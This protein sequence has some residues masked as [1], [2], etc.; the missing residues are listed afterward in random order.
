LLN[1]KKLY[2][3]QASEQFKAE[4]KIHHPSV[5]I[6]WKSSDRDAIIGPKIDQ[7]GPKWDKS[8]TFSDES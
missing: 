6:S 8:A 4:G 7:I 3:I 2:A 5:I 1:G